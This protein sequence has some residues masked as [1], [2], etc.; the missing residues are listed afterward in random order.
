MFI[1][2]KRSGSVTYLQVVENHREDGKVRQRVVGTLGRED[3]LRG[4][5]QLDGLLASGARFTENALVLL[6]HEAGRLQ[7]KAKRHIGGP[8][9]FGRLWPIF[10]TAF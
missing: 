1:R 8:K 2:R 5:G 3:D 7:E 10:D 9:V 6:A 4:G